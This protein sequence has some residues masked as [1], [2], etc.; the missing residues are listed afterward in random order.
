YSVFLQQQIAGDELDPDN[1]DA[2]VATGFLRIHPEES[3]AANFRQIRQDI[4]DDITETA[5]LTFLGL[6]VGCA[7]CH[8]HKFDPITQEDYFH[9]QAFFAGML[10]RDDAPLINGRAAQ[11]YK[12]RMKTWEEATL[13]IRT[14]MQKLLVPVGKEI[15]DEAVVGL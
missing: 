7:R 8:D 14:E 12:Q 3:N 13:S 11:E 6:T 5:G 9:F 10:P 2:L 4:L 15:V 1:P